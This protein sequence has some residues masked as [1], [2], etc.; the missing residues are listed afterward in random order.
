[1]KVWRISYPCDDTPNGFSYE[2]FSS[3]A[4]GKARLQEMKQDPDWE[5]EYD[6]AKDS[7]DFIEI[8]TNKKEMLNHLNNGWYF[9]AH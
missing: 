5:D 1:M 6:N 3:K 7:L 8:P 9:I 2:W 4:E